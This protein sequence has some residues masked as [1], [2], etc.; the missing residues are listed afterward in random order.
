MFVEKSLLRTF[1]RDFLLR[2][3][4]WDRIVEKSL[5]EKISEVVADNILQ[6][7]KSN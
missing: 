5:V 6:V 4:G 7:Y 2:E 1:C 3:F